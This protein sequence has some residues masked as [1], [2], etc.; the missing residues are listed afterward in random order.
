[1]KIF[2][3]EWPSCVTL[4][5]KRI[6]HLRQQYSVDYAKDTHRQRSYI[7]PV[8]ELIIRSIHLKIDLKLALAKSGKHLSK[9]CFLTCLL[10]LVCIVVITKQRFEMQRNAH[11]LGKKKIRF[12]Y[13]KKEHCF[14]SCLTIIFICI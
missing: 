6:H 7:R 3:S 4:I 12:K 2:S 8:L 10:P 1:M 13:I 11:S 5:V 14:N 9:S